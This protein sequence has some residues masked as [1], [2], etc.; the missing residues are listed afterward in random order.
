VRVNPHEISRL[1]RLA[2]PILMAQVAQTAMTL[3][4]TIMA[5]RY[6]AIDLAAISVASSFWLPIVLTC[7]GVIMALTPVVAQLN[8]AQKKSQIPMTVTQG[9]WLTLLIFIPA[10]ILLYA[11]PYLL[12]F[13]DVSPVMA[14]KTRLYLH[15]MLIGLP[16][17]LFYQ[18][19]RNYAEGLSH[20]IP[21]MCIGFAGLLLNVPLN[22][23]LIY[24][25]FGLPEL[26]GVGC[27]IASAAAMWFMA[28]CMLI[29]VMRSKSYD[30][31]RLF[32]CFI[33]WN[34]SQMYRL[35]KLGAP[36]AMALFCEVTL[37]SIVAL[38]LSPLGPDVVASHQVALNYSS[39]IFMLPLSLGYAVTIR[40][41]HSMGERE[42]E[43]AKTA[44]ISGFQ[45]G[46]CMTVITASL[47]ILLRHW[48]A[49]E[50]TH[51]P[52]VVT[53]AGQLIV[54]AAV[55][56]FSDTIQAISSGALRGF[57]DTRVIFYI[58]LCSYW[59][60]GIPVG[61]V[62]GLTDWIVPAMGPQGFWTGIIV[63]LTTAAVL[64]VFRLKKTIHRAI[65]AH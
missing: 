2:L 38:M 44:I 39:L 33:A 10:G 57:K 30:D 12:H 64:Y 63:G 11:S 43:L 58:T 53:L 19:L 46:L 14:E 62:L 27:G 55:Y 31:C 41:G 34:W 17:Y 28:V 40:V 3:L 54:F 15:A 45:V 4:D 22:W 18:V 13:M 37:F 60:L 25:K 23:M 7:Q 65:V 26:G 51:D 9:F 6:S 50:Y 47:T 56:Q 29:Y 32:Q 52:F 35:F 42:P 61:Y 24:G 16:A 48:I 8:G 49:R 1:V 36:I 21:G 59:L 20:T 5:G